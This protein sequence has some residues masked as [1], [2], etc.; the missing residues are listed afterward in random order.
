MQLIKSDQIDLTGNHIV[1]RESLVNIFY[2]DRG[3]SVLTVPLD[4]RRNKIQRDQMGGI[5]QRAAH[6]AETA[7]AWKLSSAVPSRFVRNGNEIALI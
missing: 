3:K 5:R 6:F 4:D 1:G 7:F 2:N